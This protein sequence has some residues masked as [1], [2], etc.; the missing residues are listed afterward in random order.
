M[1]SPPDSELPATHCAGNLSNCKCLSG[2]RLS[3]ALPSQDERPEETSLA[4][5]GEKLHIACIEE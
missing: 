5:P 2:N 1:D 3:Y 4:V